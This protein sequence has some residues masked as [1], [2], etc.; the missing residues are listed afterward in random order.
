MANF[1]YRGKDIRENFIYR[2]KVYREFSYLGK[3]VRGK[4]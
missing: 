2:K 3:D 4:I 1:V